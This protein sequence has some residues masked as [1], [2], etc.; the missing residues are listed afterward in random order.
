MNNCRCNMCH[1][2]MSSINLH[3]GIMIQSWLLYL[4]I[5]S[6]FSSMWSILVKKVMPGSKIVSRNILTFFQRWAVCL[7]EWLS[8]TSYSGWHVNIKIAQKKPALRSYILSISCFIYNLR[9]LGRGNS[10]TLE[11]KYWQH[12]LSLSFKSINSVWNIYHLQ[13]A[14][15]SLLHKTFMI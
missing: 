11:W 4:H 10:K 13:M 3:Y 12:T 5:A 6:Y 7:V 14:Y 9:L 1:T 2:T 8:V 15:V